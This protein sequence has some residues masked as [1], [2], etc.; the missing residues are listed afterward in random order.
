M[1]S[2]IECMKFNYVKEA[3]IPEQGPY[4]GEIKGSLYKSK[5]I[6]IFNI[7]ELLIQ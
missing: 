2:Y 7:S 6:Y 5:I 3:A 4:R 1:L